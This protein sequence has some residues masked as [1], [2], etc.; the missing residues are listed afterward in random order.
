MFLLNLQEE[1][2]KCAGFINTRDFAEN[3]AGIAGYFEKNR[4]IYNRILKE[5]VID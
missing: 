4:D 1:K 3:F 2:T 5:T